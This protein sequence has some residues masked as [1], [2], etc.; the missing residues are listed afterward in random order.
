MSFIY[1]QCMEWSTRVALAFACAVLFVALARICDWAPNGALDSAVASCMAHQQTTALVSFGSYITH[2]GSAVL[3]TPLL[4]VIGLASY[5]SRYP[6]AALM[7]GAMVCTVILVYALKMGFSMPRPPNPLH[8][9][10]GYGFPS[11][12]AAQ[13]TVCYGISCVVSRR[14]R[15]H[16]VAIPA[17]SIALVFLVSW[18]RLVLGV[19]YFSD[20]VGGLLLGAAVVIVVSRQMNLWKCT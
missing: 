11:G 4:F 8:S 2:A 3:C 12:H 17:L 1:D 18:S 9:S 6:C 20:I 7:A 13:A 15:W 19:H 16:D 5:K 14:R 10:R